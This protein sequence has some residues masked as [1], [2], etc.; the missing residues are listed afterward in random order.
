MDTTL[1]EED[2]MPKHTIPMG[3]AFSQWEALT[4]EYLEGLVALRRREPGASARM[5]RLAREM[6]ECEARCGG[7]VY[8]PPPRVPLGESQLAVLPEPTRLQPIKRQR[9]DRDPAPGFWTS[10]F[11][12]FLGSSRQTG[13]GGQDA[14]SR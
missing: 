10:A 11:G 2:H 1:E 4:K 3:S 12:A 13:R 5:M 7:P 9:A 6:Q 14:A 8:V